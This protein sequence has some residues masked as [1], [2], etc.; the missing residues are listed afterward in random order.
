MRDASAVQDLHRVDE[1]RALARRAG[2]PAGIRQSSMTSVHVSEAR[3]PSLFSFLPTRMPGLSRST[4][5]AE[6]PWLPGLR[7][8]TAISDRDVRRPMRS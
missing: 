8:V 6:I 5:K 7:S 1:S 4:M 3:I 2:S